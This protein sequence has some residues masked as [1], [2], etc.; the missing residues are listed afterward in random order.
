M[1]THEYPPDGAWRKARFPS[2][3]SP[4]KLLDM[5]ERFPIPSLPEGWPYVPRVSGGALEAA[6]GDFLGTGWTLFT[7][8]PVA[9]GEAPVILANAFGRGGIRRRRGSQT[10]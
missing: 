3:E 10:P 8:G 6:S 2:R 1:T 4:A 7:H 5:A 9:F